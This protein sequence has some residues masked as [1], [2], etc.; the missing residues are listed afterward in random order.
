MTTITE[1]PESVAHLVG[2][3]VHGLDP[4]GIVV[5]LEPGDDEFFAYP[6]PRRWSEVRNSY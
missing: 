1:L 6:E 3:R 4:A 5:I 2:E